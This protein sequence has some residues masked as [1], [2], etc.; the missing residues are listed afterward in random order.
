MIRQVMKAEGWEGGLD[1][2]IWHTLGRRELVGVP[3]GLYSQEWQ[4]IATLWVWMTS[5]NDTSQVTR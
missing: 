1:I 3:F 2:T 5:G 4:I